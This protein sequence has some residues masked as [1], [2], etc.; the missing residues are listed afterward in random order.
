MVT[1]RTLEVEGMAAVTIRLGSEVMDSVRIL[2][3]ELGVRLGRR[4]TQQEA[5]GLAVGLALTEADRVAEN[6][7]AEA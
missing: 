6:V 1:T 2:A 3:L 5:V 4:V 7:R